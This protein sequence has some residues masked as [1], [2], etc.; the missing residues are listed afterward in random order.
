MKHYDVGIVG[1]WYATNYGSIITYYALSYTIEKLGLRTV[2]IDRPEKEKDSEGENVIS[3]NFLREHCEISQSVSWKDYEKINDLCDSYVIGSDQV[4]THDA[5]KYMD[6]MFFLSFA[7]DS[8]RKVAYAPS[9][10]SNQFNVSEAE[11]EKIKHYLSEFNAISIREDGGKQLL[12]EKF[13]IIA[14]QTMDPV[15]LMEREEYHK[16]SIES[17][18]NVSG[19]YILAYILDPS[20]DKETALERLKEKLS[21]NVKIVLD[22]RKGTFQKNYDKFT[23]CH[24]NIIIRDVNVPD[25]IKL[26]ENAEYIFTDS[27][28]GLAMGI[29]FNK[30]LICYANHSRGYVRFTSLLGL[31]GM[32]DRMIQNADALT[33][34]LVES[35]IDY[36][37]IMLI[38]NEK[39]NTSRIWIKNALLGDKQ[40]VKKIEV[41]LPKKERV[42]NPDFER[43]RM[44]VSMLKQYGIKHVVLSSGSRNLNLCR[45]FEAHSW[46]KTYPVIDERSAGFYGIGLALELKRPVAICC[47]SGTAASNYLTAV[48]EA[49]YQGIPLV[50]I[51]ADRYPCFLGQ[52]EDQTI[53]QTMIF[54]QVCKKSVSLPVNTGYLADWET[55]RMIADALLEVTH[56]G[57]GP[58]QINVPIQNIQ[59]LPPKKEELFLWNYRKIN[60]TTIADPYCVWTDY[61]RKLEKAERILLVY[62]Q[63]PLLEEAEKKCVLEFINKYNC[64]IIVDHL[65]N[66]RET[67][68]VLSFPIVKGM[69]QQ[70]FNDLLSPNIVIT[71]GGKRMLNDPVTYKLRGMQKD[72]EH[73]RVAEDGKVVDMFRRLSVVF[74]CRQDYFFHY[75]SENSQIVNNRE[76]LN[77]WKQLEKR[78]SNTNHMCEYGMKYTIEKLMNGIP[79]NSLF[80]I[81]VGNTVMYT[82]IYPLKPN[83]EVYCNMGTNGIDGCAS[84]YM[85]HVAATNKMTFLSIGDLSFFYDLNSVFNKELKSNIRIF[86][87]NNHGAELLRDHQS[88]AITHEHHMSAKDYVLSLGFY[89]LSATNK[90]EFEVALKIFLSDKIGKPIFFEVF[91]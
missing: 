24:K 14:E 56:H 66:F 29:I 72:F 44:V 41:T 85:G 36:S 35:K 20:Y 67:D 70:E 81:A 83:V 73:W 22:G 69:S 30:Q 91:T 84:T 10:G 12:Q 82:N 59:R 89:Y 76:Y 79:D 53:P 43:C 42:W 38:L 8:K 2:L 45:F 28:H 52:M 33:D 54:H 40:K 16:I 27:H 6:Y 60:R 25:W 37:N 50:V 11:F 26:F 32:E 3:R 63:N 51:T 18:I 77:I 74:E 34:R 13:G 58:V 57:N 65:S 31:L 88:P 23:I 19:K 68:T 62:G 4:W 7:D 64:V 49:Y 80:H 71:V 90:E 75:F 39:I 21:I 48:T 61:V 9:F 55:R 47:T 78:F 87:S 15:F 17:D 5:I 1:Y 46:F 86:M